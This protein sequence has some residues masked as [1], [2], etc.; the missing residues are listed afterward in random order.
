MKRRNFKTSLA[1]ILTPKLARIQNAGIDISAGFIVGFDNDDESIFEDQFQFIQDN[2][3]VLG[4][5]RHAHGDTENA[6]L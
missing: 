5:G 3:I 4:D 1:M 6:A 2:G